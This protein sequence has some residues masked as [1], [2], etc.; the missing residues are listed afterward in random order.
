MPKAEAQQC[1][2][3]P[4][5][6]PPR[7]FTIE[8]NQH[9]IT[10]QG[11]VGSEKTKIILGV[12]GETDKTL[13]SEFTGVPQ[14]HQKKL[15]Q[16]MTKFSKWPPGGGSGRKRRGWVWGSKQVGGVGS[17]GGGTICKKLKYRRQIF[18]HIDG[19]RWLQKFELANQLCQWDWPINLFRCFCLYAHS[20]FNIY[21]IYSSKK[22]LWYLYLL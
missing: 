14:W 16:V 4:P 15:P 12:G 9:A 22:K 2:R 20:L 3:P 18:T 1:V 11:E 6:S 13:F 21:H 8:G 19:E 7:G 17:Q 10:L 5:P